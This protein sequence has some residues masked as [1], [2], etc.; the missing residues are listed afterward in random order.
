MELFWKAAFVFLVF[1]AVDLFRQMRRHKQDL[2]MS[3]QDIKDEM[4]EMEGNPQMKRGFAGCS[5]T[6]RGGK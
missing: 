4:K 5:A 1:G 3:K 6:G 2:R